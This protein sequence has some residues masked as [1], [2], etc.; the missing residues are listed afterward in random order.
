MASFLGEYEGCA[1][2]RE[3]K[4]VRAVNSFL[5]NDYPYKELI[6]VSDG[7]PI[8]IELLNKS[9]KDQLLS[10]EIKLVKLKKQKLFSGKVRSAGIAVST[11]NT[12]MYLDTD[13][14]L[15]KGHISSV[16]T[17]MES[18]ELDWCYYNDWINTDKG[19]ISKS[20]E[21]EHGSIGT[22]SIAHIVHPKINWKKCD[23]YGHD[24][25]FVQ[26]LMEWSDNCDRIYG[27][28]YIICHI[29]NQIDQ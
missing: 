28:T 15:G 14:M 19:L 1:S 25:K 26:K 9:F 4:F 16:M 21:L 27:T 12:I 29:P 3:E 13:D 24:F 22:S 8:T 2:N 17:Q 23:D 20:V 11:G 10:G 5:E 6:V 7:C 18:N